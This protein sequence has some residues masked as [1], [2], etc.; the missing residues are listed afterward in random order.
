MQAFKLQFST[1]LK[2]IALIY[3]LYSLS[4]LFFYFENL[5]NFNSISFGELL[6]VFFYGLRFDTFSIMAGNSLFIL[7]S[8]LPSTFVTE[9][10]FQKF[11][12]YLFVFTNALFL[13]FNYIDMAY[14]SFI[15]KR[16]TSDIFYQVGGQ[17]DVM[18]QIPYYFRDFWHV[19]LLFT[20]NIYLMLKYYPQQKK[21]HENYSYTFKNNLKYVLTIVLTIGLTFLGIR[22][23]NRIP[24][25]FADAGTYTKPQYVSLVLNTPFCILKSLD[26]Q[27]LEEY[28]FVKDEYAQELIQPI[29]HYKDKTFKEQNIVILLLESFSK[30]YTGIGNRRSITPFLDSLMKHS[31][32]FTNAWANGTKSIEGIPAILSSIPS[33]ANDP[34]INSPYCN[35]N[36]N[37]LAGL[38]K[39]KN[40][41]TAFMH[42]GFNG[43]MSFDAFA[44]QAGFDDYYGK[45]EYNNDADFDDNW[46][47]YDEPY[48]QYC[49][50]K[51]SEFKSPF[52]AS[53]FTLSSHHPYKVP[54][55][56]EGK[57]PKT[58]LENSESIGY[59]DYSVKRFFESAAKTSWYKNTL[60]VLVADHASISSDPFYATTLGQ[61][62]IPI[63][64]FKP[65]GSFKGVNSQLM[66]QIDILPSLMDTI[67]Y[68]EPF[69]SFGKSIFSSKS[70]NYA[71]YYETGNHYLI[72]D[73]LFI[74]Y[75][76][77]KPV[78]TIAFRTDSTL[79]INLTKANTT[80]ADN[81]LKSFV[82]LY[83]STI[84]HN[85]MC[86]KPEQ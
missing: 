84:I 27:K 34:F 7:L 64:F 47:I 43:T 18:K 23:T 52:F 4:R 76:Q 6:S 59:A 35:N 67:G 66:Q 20:V 62:A 1:L 68:N 80:T 55:Q 38:L 25:D 46:G 36:N 31:L 21:H 3:A 30:E 51:L 54:K 63:L 72:S 22:G 17:T 53:I 12:K 39:T 42:G 40:Y 9:I 81:Y 28:H 19:I 73:S 10:K 2:R 37:S 58:E 48:L 16:S 71:L 70:K 78:Q 74:V 44:K 15:G 83:N 86:I 69:F 61:H 65:D 24:L 45:N 77:F 56:Y 75:N 8:V 41:Y 32:V 29:K 13:A 85:K 26:K 33:L 57:F 82:Q 5:R 50:K 49:C 11:L 79:N 14:F 60:F